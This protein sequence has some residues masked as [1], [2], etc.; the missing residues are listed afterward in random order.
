MQVIYKIIDADTLYR[1]YYPDIII[2]I[3]A[4]KGRSNVCNLGIYRHSISYD[5]MSRNCLAS[6][7]LIAM[8]SS[9]HTAR[10]SVSIV[11]NIS[12]IVILKYILLCT[13]RE[14]YHHQSYSVPSIYNKIYAIEHDAYMPFI[15]H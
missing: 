4:I 8:N 3:R 9:S 15:N 6:A 12:N 1:Y 11:P 13:G 10:N 5:N 7:F 2:F 14:L